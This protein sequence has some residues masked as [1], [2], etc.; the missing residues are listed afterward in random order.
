[1]Q[2]I[3][4]RHGGSIVPESHPQQGATFYFTIGGPQ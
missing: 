2:R 3:L 4:H 1:V